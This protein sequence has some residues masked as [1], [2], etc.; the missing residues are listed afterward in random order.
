MYEHLIKKP[1]IVARQ[2]V[3]LYRFEAHQSAVMSSVF[4][5]VKGLYCA[6]YYLRS[7]NF[8]VDKLHGVFEVT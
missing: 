5:F 7:Q 2:S 3:D 6:R 1:K 8:I 4:S